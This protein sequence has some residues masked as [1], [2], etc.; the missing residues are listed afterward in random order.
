M[1]DMENIDPSTLKSLAERLKWARDRKEWSQPH[2]AVVAG[3]STSTVGMIENGHRQNKGSLPALA[4]ALDVRYRWLHFGELPVEDPEP[5]HLRDIEATV[6]RVGAA[7][8]A[9]LK[10]HYANRVPIET[11]RLLQ[12]FLTLLEVLPEERKGVALEGAIL[13][14]ANH[15]QTVPNPKLDPLAQ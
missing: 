8:A 6:E 2:L 11:E 7:K 15:L 13:V 5:R 1:R 14:V 3:V 9:E 10:A 4:Q 12:T